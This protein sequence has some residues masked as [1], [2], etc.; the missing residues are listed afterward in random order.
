[1][2]RRP[3][4]PFVRIGIAGF[5][6]VATASLAQAQVAGSV[7]GQARVQR[8]LPERAALIRIKS[9]LRNLVIAQETYFAD[10]Q[11]YAGTLDLL[12]FRPSDNVT[13]TLTFTQN[14][15]WAAEAKS[16]ALPTVVCSI[17][18]NVAEQYRSK[19][20]NASAAAEGEPVCDL[21]ATTQQD[22]Q[23]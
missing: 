14:N 17:Y 16:A 10:H 3:P 19:R 7:A 9:D 1:M 20:K 22:K 11:S 2:M 12:H 18:I 6:V 5:L 13:P 23:Q 8:D 4:K 21:I 15:G